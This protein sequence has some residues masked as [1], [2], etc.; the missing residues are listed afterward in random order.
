MKISYADFRQWLIVRVAETRWASTVAESQMTIS[1]LAQKLGVQSDV[2][3]EAFELRRK[4]GRSQVKAEVYTGYASKCIHVARLPMS[5]VK[6]LEEMAEEREMSRSE[7]MRTIIHNYLTG[8]YE[9]SLLQKWHKEER[10]KSERTF[11]IAMRLNRSA[12]AA[13]NERAD[14]RGAAALRITN[15]LLYEAVLAPEKVTRHH[16]TIKQL[17]PFERYKKVIDKMR[18]EG[19]NNGS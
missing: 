16:V 17:W 8:T 9:P 3:V 2:I 12:I 1:D 11:R 6:Q 7:L 4:S 13:M 15:A 5:I 10:Y 18:K 19:A 14:L